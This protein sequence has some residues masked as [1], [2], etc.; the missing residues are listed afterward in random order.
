M[1][2]S[3]IIYSHKTALMMVNSMNGKYCF[4]ALVRV[5]YGNGKMSKGDERTKEQ[6]CENI[7][8]KR[9]ER[10]TCEEF[11]EEKA[12]NK[13]CAGGIKLVKFIS[14]QQRHSNSNS[15]NIVVVITK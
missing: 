15:T 11:E 5:Q 7:M 2:Y 4:P 6:N 12:I 8:K 1:A 3:R 13:L 9:K 10:N 14:T